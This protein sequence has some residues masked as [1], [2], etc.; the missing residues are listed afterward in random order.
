MICPNCNTNLPDDATVCTSCEAEVATP[1]KTP[2]V[3]KMKYLGKLAS[4]KSKT[5][6]ILSW[7]I[8]L[9]CIVLLTVGMIQAYTRPV[10]EIAIIQTVVPDMATEFE[11]SWGD[12][13]DEY[14][15]IHDE[16]SKFQKKYDELKKEY[17][18]EEL[19]E[20]MEKEIGESL[21]TEEFNKIKLI[22]EGGDA[23][24]ENPSIEN[25]QK[26][27]TILDDEAFE[28]LLGETYSEIPALVNTII[29]ALFVFFAVIILLTL[30]ITLFK[31]TGLTVF[32]QFLAVIFAFL[33]AGTTQT[34]ILA[35][36][37]IVLAVL[38]RIINKEYKAYR[39]TA[40]S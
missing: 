7:G 21:D 13:Q 30:L 4:K 23:F 20:Q 11:K 35:I 6:N 32:T 27:A 10:Y 5:A 18:G 37:Y 24:I 25:T 39:K 1:K 34:I 19:M 9:V 3:R 38:F 31:K 26:M 36:A 2:P 8:C 15:E 29:K 40:R 33:F 16:Y 17:D 22:F 14:E 28:E 12:I